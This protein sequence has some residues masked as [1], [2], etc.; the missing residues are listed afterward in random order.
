M[1]MKMK[2]RINKHPLNFNN[3]NAYKTGL[4]EQFALNNSLQSTTNKLVPLSE[5]NNSGL[6]D[7]ELH[8]PDTKQRTELISSWNNRLS[9]REFISRG[10][11]I[12]QKKIIS[13]SV[14]ITQIRVINGNV[15]TECSQNRTV[16][17]TR[18]HWSWSRKS[19]TKTDVCYMLLEKLTTKPIYLTRRYNKF[20]LTLM[21]LR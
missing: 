5:W 16:W 14:H 13:K 6:T 18:W 2:F 1:I 4:G 7:F 8:E 20:F 9:R 21:F 15:E 11:N 17:Y 19:S 12:N 10:K 3:F